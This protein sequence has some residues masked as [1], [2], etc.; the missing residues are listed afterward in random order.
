MNLHKT[1]AIRK[2]WRPL[3]WMLNPSCM[4]FTITRSSVGISTRYLFAL[5]VLQAC[6]TCMSD[7]DPWEARRKIQSPRLVSMKFAITKFI[8]STCI[9][10]KSCLEVI[11]N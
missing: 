9:A 3:T 11:F 10:S 8:N 2:P 7:Q 5:V 6:M 4:T 1:F